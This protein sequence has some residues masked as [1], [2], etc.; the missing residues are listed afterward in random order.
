[1]PRRPA[2][3][4]PALVLVVSLLAGAVACGSGAP[5]GAAA[6]SSSA[7]PGAGAVAPAAL[8]DAGVS[9]I[10]RIG[11]WMIAPDG[12]I[13]AW[14]GMSLD[15]KPFREPINVV[16]VDSGAKD[17]DD[18]KAR[19]VDAMTRA[20]YPARTGHTSGYR[21]LIDGVLH[22]QLPAQKDHAFSTHPFAENN[23]H[24]R[25]FGP[26]RTAEGWVFV[27]SL[28]RENVDYKHMPPQHVYASFR[29][30]RDELAAALDDRTAYRRAETVAL[31]N[32]AGPD[33]PFTVGDHDG[34]AVVVRAG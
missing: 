2:R 21:G 1:M 15:G 7:A 19:L 34:N 33:V 25:I 13:A 4:L 20:G 14:L 29:R 17:G 5:D 6:S 9:G 26:Q 27:G 10:G 28:S 16:F 30:A 31:G 8:A 18:A 22:G 11:R 12:Q 23:N 32:G 24:G 3:D